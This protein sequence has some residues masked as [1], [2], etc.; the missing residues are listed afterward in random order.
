MLAER[1]FRGV[2]EEPVCRRCSYRSICDDSAA[3]GVPSWPVV[4][5]GGGDGVPA[6]EA[7]VVS[8]A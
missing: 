4:D 8:P 3:P 5:D 1:E 2:A 7:P 6:G